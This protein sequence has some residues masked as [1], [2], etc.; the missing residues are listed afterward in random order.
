MIMSPAE[1]EQLHPAAR[2]LLELY[3]KEEHT[4]LLAEVDQ[5]SKSGPLPPDVL[6]L[7]AASLLAL[8]RYDEAL[9]AARH[10]AAQSP[11]KAWLQHLLGRAELARGDRQKALEAAEAA[12]RLMP[13]QPDYLATLTACQ[14]ASG[15]LGEAAAAARRALAVAPDHAGALYEL[16]LTLADSGDE[17]GALEHLRRAQA[18]DPRFP[19]AYLAEADL[20]RKAGRT[21][22]AR[23]TL[24]RALAAM[25]DLVE[26]E[27][28]LAATV[29]HSA[30]V[31]RALVHLIHLSRLT[32]TGWLIVAF[33]YYL[34]FRLL[35][36]LWKHF[37]ALLPAGRALLVATALWLLGG[38][39]A[40][41]LTRAVL[42]RI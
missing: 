29:G 25:P 16:G 37:A 12:C 17:A 9:K 38:A 8:E 21:A 18:A 7:A 4:A 6:G 1:T 26:A 40:G 20:H 10:A 24:Q 34:F 27:E 30:L 42:R 31:Q 39:A 11:R 33:L 15:R 3:Q 36:F 23:R 35:E 14:R 19:A 5:Q 28:R 22:E 13:D 2:S 41:R 32:V